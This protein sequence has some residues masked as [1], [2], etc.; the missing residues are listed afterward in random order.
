MTAAVP[1]NFAEIAVEL[2]LCELGVDEISFAIHLEALV[3]TKYLEALRHLAA[4]IELS[5]SITERILNDYQRRADALGAAHRLLKAWIPHEARLLA[6]TA[7]LQ[8][9]PA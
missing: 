2:R 6:L 8:V 7:D 9:L 1:L 5:P 3:A 4:R